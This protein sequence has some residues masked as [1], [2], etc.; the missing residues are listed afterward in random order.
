[1]TNPMNE[2]L[3]PA[4]RAVRDAIGEADAFWDEE[5]AAAVLRAA[6]AR[7]E[8]LIGDTPHPK[9]AEGVLA[10]VEFLQRTAAELEAPNV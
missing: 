4:A 8:D 5:V 3:S 9:F 1:M 7:T 2:L 10:A 6:S